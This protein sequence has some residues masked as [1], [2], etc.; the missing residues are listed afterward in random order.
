MDFKQSIDLILNI[1]LS[2]YNKIKPNKS[3]I[4]I[5]SIEQWVINK[6]HPYNSIEKIYILPEPYST[7]CDDTYSTLELVNKYFNSTKFDDNHKS[8]FNDMYAP[9]I[10]IEINPMIWFSITQ[11][12]IIQI[13]EA[14]IF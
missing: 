5:S 3:S 4:N 6:I 10:Q 14:N 8:T 11:Y 13:I 7:E 9:V 1:M 2:W 12:E